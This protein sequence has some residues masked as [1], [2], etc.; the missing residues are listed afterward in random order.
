[1][2]DQVRH[3]REGGGIW[4][5]YST[6]AFSPRQERSGGRGSLEFRFGQELLRIER[7]HA[8]RP[9]R[10]HRLPVDL[11]HDVAAGEDAGD[12]GAGGA[13]LDLDIAV[14]IEREL[15]LEQL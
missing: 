10:R 11:V 15:A 8:T 7:G 14:R 6:S 12:V 13:G 2:P 4:I 3:D 5:A 9:R 1:M